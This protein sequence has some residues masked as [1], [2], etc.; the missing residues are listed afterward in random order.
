MQIGILAHEIRHRK[1]IVGMPVAVAGGQ[2][3]ADWIALAIGLLRA[4]NAGRTTA[5]KNSDAL[6]SIPLC[7]S[8]HVLHETILLQCQ[9]G[10]AVV[11]AVEVLQV[12][13]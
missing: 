10:Q 8:L 9:M 5:Q 11:A 2:G 7:R 6:P 13:A 3:T 12:G 1:H 4:E